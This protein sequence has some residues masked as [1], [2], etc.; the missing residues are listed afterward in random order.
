ME[1][2]YCFMKYCLIMQCEQIFGLV[3][4]QDMICLYSWLF[5]QTRELWKNKQALVIQE[6]ILQGSKIWLFEFPTNS[7]QHNFKQ[8][9]RN[10]KAHTQNKIK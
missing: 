2:K 1:K 6:K 8:L 7:N 3:Y 5:N 9:L 4:Q 10:L